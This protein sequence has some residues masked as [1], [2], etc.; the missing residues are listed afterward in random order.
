[1]KRK[2]CIVPKTNQKPKTC[3]ACSGS[4][5]W[6]NLDRKGRQIPCGACDGKG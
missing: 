5:W 3:V 2:N 1:M 6:D 4:G